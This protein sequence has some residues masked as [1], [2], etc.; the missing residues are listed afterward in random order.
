MSLNQLFLINGR[1]E[2]A[3]SPLDRGLSYGDGVFRTIR[4]QKGVPDNWN[5]HFNK[6]VEDCNV[7]GIVCP[8]TELLLTDIERLFS[9]KDSVQ[10]LAVAKII[11][12]RG[13]GARGY[14]V[15][16]LAQPNRIVIKSAFPE[17]PAVNF[18]DGVQLHLCKL[19]LSYQPLL[20]GI[21]HL[22]R[23][24]NV[25]ARMEWKDS[26]IAEGIMLDEKNNVIE[27]TA[28][29][30]FARYDKTL[31]TSDLSHCGVAGV[32]RQRI[33]ELVPKLNL[34]SRVSQITLNKLMQADEI[35]ICNSLYGAWQ[36][37][38]F[39]G[40]QFPNLGLASQLRNI[41]QE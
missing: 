38:T 26:A 14:A 37:K 31:L 4:I 9:G 8:S 36:V 27:C 1:S 40:Q 10:E 3:L 34:R 2:H 21:K 24:E 33:L 13:E 30:L 25:M 5:L 29:N 35:I 19:R 15:P 28:S 23:L 17:Y 20:A 6:L 12:T 22:N 32:T 39:N 18:N 7:L 41:L 11:I 16:S